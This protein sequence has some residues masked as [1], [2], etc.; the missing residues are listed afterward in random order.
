LL[1]IAHASGRN[2]MKTLG[3]NLICEKRPFA[4][5][6]GVKKRNI[7]IYEKHIILLALVSGLAPVVLPTGYMILHGKGFTTN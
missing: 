2:K 7:L 3:N 5:A 6:S 1:P 4:H